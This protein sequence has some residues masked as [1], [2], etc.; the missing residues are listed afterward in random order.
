[1]KTQLSERYLADNGCHTG[2]YLVAWFNSNRQR[3]ERAQ[4][5]LG[6]FRAKLEAQAAKESSA[7][8][9]LRAWVLDCSLLRPA[10]LTKPKSR[11]KPAAP[12]KSAQ[13]R[14]MQRSAR[15]N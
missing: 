15:K 14:R 2:L 7:G 13:G 1:M 8:K 11:T 5:R 4:E 9:N 12:G 6:E 10:K 3:G